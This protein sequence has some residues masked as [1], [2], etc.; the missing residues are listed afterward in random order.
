MHTDASLERSR[1]V[2]VRRPPHTQLLQRESVVY[3]F[4][5]SRRFETNAKALKANGFVVLTYL[6][7]FVIGSQ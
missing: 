1:E 7:S 3:S 4:Y 6:L 5:V 2:S